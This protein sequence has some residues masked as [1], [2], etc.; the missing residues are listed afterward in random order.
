MYQN[1]VEV[2]GFVGNVDA[3]RT[4]PNGRKVRNFSLG[5]SESWKSKET[6]E[7]VKGE[8]QWHKVAVFG[9]AAELK[10]LVKGA[11]LLVSGKLQYNNSE[12]T[13][14][15]GVTVK[16]QNAQIIAN[17]IRTM[18]KTEP[19]E[20]AGTPAPEGQSG[21]LPA[22]IPGNMDTFVDDIPF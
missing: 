18:S 16:T 7:Y 17:V 20:V 8:T 13:N 6:G 14:K 21:D 12:Y 4:M 9:N 22:D 11:H 5:T 19:K 3:V 15:E 2:I 10:S 1:N